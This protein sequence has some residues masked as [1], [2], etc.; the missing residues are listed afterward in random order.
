MNLGLVVASAVA[1]LGVA[2][3]LLNVDP[4]SDRTAGY[5]GAALIGAA[6]GLTA[7]PLFWLVAF[8]LRHRIAYRGAWTRALRRATWVG[9]LAG[10]FV[11]MRLEGLFQVPIGLFLGVLA[12]VAEIAL[13]N[14]R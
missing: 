12:L 6:M 1:W 10:V 2:L 13:T 9:V 7:A 3:V 4:R 11:V 5:V 14:Q 8:A